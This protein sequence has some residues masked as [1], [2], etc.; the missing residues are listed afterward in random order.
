MD[1]TR[2]EIVQCGMRPVVIVIVY[3]RANLCLGV[4]E[5]AERAEINT[6]VLERTPEA[7]DEHVVHPLPLAVHRDPD[8]V[9]TKSIGLGGAG[10]LTA[11]IGVEDL[12]TPVSL[13]SF[14]ERLDT[15]PRILRVG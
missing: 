13:D 9:L 3:P 8:F 14:V 4:F 11:L 1:F 6:L 7:L 12:W 5:V 15:E 10:E 2:R